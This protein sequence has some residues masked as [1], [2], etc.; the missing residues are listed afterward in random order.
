MTSAMSPI[1]TQSRQCSQLFGQLSSLLDN[2]NTA[3]ATHLTIYLDEHCRFRVWANNIG[4]LLTVEHRNSLDFRLRNALKVSNRVVE[5][6]VDLG[7]ALAD[8]ESIL[9]TVAGLSSRI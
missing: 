1:A 2:G 6:L 7:E 5:F 4:A 3:D 9:M 8:G